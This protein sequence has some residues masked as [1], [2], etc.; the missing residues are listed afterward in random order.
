MNCGTII[1]LYRGP[2][3]LAYT[4]FSGRFLAVWLFTLLFAMWQEFAERSRNPCC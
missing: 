1:R 2:L 4:R 3:P